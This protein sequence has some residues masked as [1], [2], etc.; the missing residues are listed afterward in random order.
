MG[1]SRPATA[2]VTPCHWLHLGRG[3]PL[4]ALRQSRI[5][6]ACVRGSGL[7]LAC[8]AAFIR[9]GRPPLAAAAEQVQRRVESR[10]A[11]A[12]FIWSRGLPLGGVGSDY[13]AVTR[14]LC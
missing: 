13:S 3:K 8:E 11:H 5:S 4:G 12:Q 9:S 7:F 1:A 6:A 10:E 2:L 14:N